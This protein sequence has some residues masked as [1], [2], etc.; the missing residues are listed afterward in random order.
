MKKLDEITI[1]IAGPAMSGKSRIAYLVKEMMKI[2]GLKVNF[3]PTPDF[4]DEMDFNRTMHVH[5]DDAMK[6]IGENTVVT[7]KE[8]QLGRE[9]F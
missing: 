7:V 1:T 8:V 3:D 4:K 6:G 9:H 2:H 5:L